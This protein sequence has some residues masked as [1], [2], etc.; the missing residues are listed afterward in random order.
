MEDILNDVV[1]FS[2]PNPREESIFQIRLNTGTSQ[3]TIHDLTFQNMNLEHNGIKGGKI[4]STGEP[5][6]LV[7]PEADA[8]NL[9]RMAGRKK[10]RTFTNRALAQAVINKYYHDTDTPKTIRLEV[11]KIRESSSIIMWKLS[12]EPETPEEVV[13][14]ETA[15]TI[16][17]TPDD[18]LLAET[19]ETLGETFYSNSEGILFGN[20]D[21]PN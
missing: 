6:I 16:A 14:T 3:F 20:E 9:K 1:D 17:S 19:D 10:G 8:T 15:G 18:N 7:V 4:G 21:E 12:L 13:E 11:E 2:T 5:V